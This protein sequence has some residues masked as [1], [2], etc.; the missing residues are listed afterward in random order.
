MLFL[1]RGDE[2][3]DPAKPQLELVLRLRVGQADETLPAVSKRGAGKHGDAGLVEQAIGELVLV[4]TGTLDVRERIERTL[5]P[6]AAHARNF[7]DAVDDQVPPV[8]EHLHHAVH[9]VPSEASS[10]RSMR[11]PLSSRSRTGFGT[12]P[13]KLTCD[14]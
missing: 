11:K 7:V 10:S 12:P 2:L 5:R 3:L 6:R 14:A 4:E 9:R 8:L 1:V 13:M